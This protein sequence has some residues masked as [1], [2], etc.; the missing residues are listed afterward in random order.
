LTAGTNE[1]LISTPGNPVPV[2]LRAIEVQ[3]KYTPDA[4]SP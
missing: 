4:T 2:A 1:L 3:L